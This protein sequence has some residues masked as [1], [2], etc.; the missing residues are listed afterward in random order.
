MNCVY[1]DSSCSPLLW[2][3][4]F[5]SNILLWTGLIRS[6]NPLLYIQVEVKA[7]DRDFRVWH[8]VKLSAPCELIRIRIRIRVY[9]GPRCVFACMNHD[10]DQPC[11]AVQQLVFHTIASL[12]HPVLIH[13]EEISS[14]RQ[15]WGFS[16]SR[17]AWDINDRILGILC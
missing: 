12:G 1:R 16:Q 6:V 9:A 10:T 3:I 2:L 5:I 13:S 17:Q 7:N 8:G 14:S 4:T 15:A 11:R